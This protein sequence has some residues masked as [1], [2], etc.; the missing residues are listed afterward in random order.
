MPDFT[1]R[2]AERNAIPTLLDMIRELADYEHMLHAVVAD[3][4]EMADWMFVRRV[5]E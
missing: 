5:A 2:F 3:P 4:D 1:I